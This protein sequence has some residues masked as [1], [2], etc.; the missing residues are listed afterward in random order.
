MQIIILQHPDEVKRPLSTAIIAKQNL[1]HCQILIGEDFSGHNDLDAL[2][3]QYEGR[4]GV[5]FPSDVSL[6]LETD[7]RNS[8]NQDTALEAMIVLDGTWR[9]AYKMWQLAKPLHRLPQFHLPQDLKGNYRLRKA[10]ADNALSTVESI[11]SLLLIAEGNQPAFEQLTQV[12]DAMIEKQ[13]ARIPEHIKA[14]NYRF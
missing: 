10:P 14:R 6:E 2:L 11:A 13:M 8:A 3:R 7:L 1:S 4:V 12:F 9:K 5:L